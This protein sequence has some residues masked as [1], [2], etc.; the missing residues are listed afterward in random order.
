M[1]KI[2]KNILIYGYFNNN[3]GDDL[4]IAMA[5]KRLKKAYPSTKLFVL[6]NKAYAAKKVS[7]NICVPF[8]YMSVSKV[9]N[10]LMVCFHNKKINTFL[11]A[12]NK[13]TVDRFIRKHI[14]VILQIGGSMFQESR[15]DSAENSHKT[16]D[17]KCL[18]EI[19]R[20]LLVPRFVVGCNFGPFSTQ[21]YYDYFSEFF[22]KCRNVY[23][24]D[25]NS[26]NM[27]SHIEPCKNGGDSAFLLAEERIVSCDDKKCTIS[28]M[29]FENRIG[30]QANSKYLH[31]ICELAE[32]YSNLGYAVTF[33]GFCKKEGDDDI[34]QKALSMC[35]CHNI[36]ALY[37]KNNL[38]SIINQFA[39]S[40]IV[41]GSRFH[42]M[43]LGWIFQKKTFVFSYSDKTLDFLKDNKFPKQFVCD[44]TR[45]NIPD[46]DSVI[47]IMNNY[48]NILSK[49]EF[50]LILENNVQNTNLMFDNIIADLKLDLYNNSK[51]NQGG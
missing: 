51:N 31:C 29:N 19:S 26:F 6:D 15:A 7:S 28:V 23:F 49:K 14:G 37:Y 35:R 38:Y 4:I 9:L 39:S 30:A 21:Y 20:G 25:Q 32:K 50:Q 46:S 5:A 2:M 18:E 22:K 24:R 41:I 8:F 45:D 12:L 36:N 47:R 27:F 3:F 17:S 40:E 13:R 10:K 1:R 42:S 43:I 34:I 33:V 11:N 16:V 48:F 44:I